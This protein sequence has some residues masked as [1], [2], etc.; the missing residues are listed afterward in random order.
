MKNL[1]LGKILIVLILFIGTIFAS[2]VEVKVDKQE[3][4]RGDT[5]KY[6]ITAQGDSVEFPQISEINGT[7]IQSVGDSYQTVI[8]NSNVTK[9]HTRSYLLAPEHNITIGSLSV[10]VDG[11]EYKTKPIEITVVKPTQAK[12][13][14]PYLLEL[15]ANKT[16]ARVGEPIRLDILFKQ[17]RD[18]KVNRLNIVPPNTSNFW[19]KDLGDFKQSLSG[20]Y[21]IQKKSFLIFPQKEGNFT[22]PAIEAQ[23]GFLVKS[24]DDFFNDPFFASFNNNIKWKRVFS[25]PLKIEVK[26][27]PDNLDVYGDFNIEAMVD[28]TEVQANKP[29]NLTIKI[30]GIGNIDDIEKFNINLPDAIVYADEP[31]IKTYIKNGKYQGV[32]KEKVAIIADKS[33]TIPAIKFTY[34]DSKTNTK[35]TIS[36]KPINIIVKGGSAVTTTK[37]TPKIEESKELKESINP[38]KTVKKIIIKPNK[39]Q[40]WLYF[41]IGLILGAILTLIIVKFKPNKTKNKQIPL[42]KQILKAKTDKEL[43]N[44]LLPYAKRGDFI[45]ETLNKLEENIYKNAKHKIK[46]EDIVDYFEEIKQKS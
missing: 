28:K 39:K 40:N 14:A 24:R 1:N 4:Y 46:K 30:T 7:K 3:I 8:I 16:K 5:V 33:Y 25:N 42:A 31:K 36:T 29:V 17:R 38:Q 18:V 35:K 2:G 44:I 45:E 32:F 9:S 34:F 13:G 12:A 23:V 19:V 26:P 15:K 10:K 43:Y 20:N 27:L 6:S 11:K 41:A 21:I 22:I 37:N